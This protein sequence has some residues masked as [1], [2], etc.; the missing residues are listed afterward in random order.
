MEE[1]EILR[2]AENLPLNGNLVV[3]VWLTWVLIATVAIASSLSLLLPEAFYPNQTQQLTFLTNDAVNLI[4]G[5]PLLGLSL[6]F[7]KKNKLI[8]LIIWYGGLFYV[9]YNYLAYVFGMPFGWQTILNSAIIGLSL[10]IGILI[11]RKVDFEGLEGV[12]GG[13]GP[14]KAASILILIFGLGFFI[15][16]VIKVSGF[17]SGSGQIGLEEVGV[18]AAD[19]AGSVMWLLSGYFLL[20]RKPIGFLFGW[21]GL[22]AVV[23]LNIGLLAYLVLQPLIV[24]GAFEALDFLIIV[25]FSA[26]CYLPLGMFLK[27]LNNSYDESHSIQGSG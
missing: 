19:L 14:R 21:S 17:L 18:F 5:L 16:A 3:P 24:G 8:G 10:V 2:G 13:V 11:F 6:W 15:Q 12:V 4:I 1:Y 22:V 26:L 23:V 25:A 27:G 20:S 9:I 7:V